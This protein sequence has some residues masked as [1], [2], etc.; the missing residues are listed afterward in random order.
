MSGAV[1]PAAPSVA[2][3]QALQLDIFVDAAAWEGLF[4]SLEVWRS[5]I[6]D[7]GPYEP[8]TGDGWA[9]ARVPAGVSGAAPAVPE[10]GPSVALSGKTLFLLVNEKTQ[11]SVVFTGLDPITFGS[12]A[13]QITS[14]GLSLV[15]AFVLSNNLVIETIQPGSGT[16]LRVVGG[17]AAPLLG[18]MTTEP[19][20]LGFGRDARIPLVRGIGNYLF[21]D[22]NGDK[23]FFY[24][25][26]FFNTLT[27]V[28]SDFSLPFTGNFLTSVSP[29][30]L[31]RAV[32]DVVDQNGNAVSGQKI[33]VYNRFS[34][35][36]IEGKTNVGG[37][38]EAST[39]NDGHAEF[40]LLRGSQVTVALPGTNIVRDVVVPTDQ[41][42]Q[43]FSLLDAA[44]GKDDLFNVQR[45]DIAF[46]ARRSL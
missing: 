40:L 3:A 32:V 26:R 23:E 43:T 21:T 42:I 19:G 46:A 25:T 5:R 8:L 20:S 44:Y 29:Q 45:P 16:I 24:K 39:N 38:L 35:M 22:L 11:L 36:Q 7:G 17:D 37:P 9:A 14:G 10:T 33:L 28:A 13:S 12:A 6:T 27:R 2:T 18:L 30:S 15:K 31:V 34:G 1:S 4:D 41:T